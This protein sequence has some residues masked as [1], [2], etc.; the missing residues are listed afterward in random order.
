MTSRDPVQMQPSVAPTG[1]PRTLC[2]LP[3]VLGGAPPK[4][5]PRGLG[6]SA[7]CPER[8]S[9]RHRNGLRTRVCSGEK[10]LLPTSVRGRATFAKP[11]PGRPGGSAGQRA[12]PRARCSSVPQRGARKNQPVTRQ[13]VQQINVPCTLPSKVNKFKKT[14]LFYSVTAVPVPPASALPCS[15][16]T[17]NPSSQRRSHP[18]VRAKKEVTKGDQRHFFSTVSCVV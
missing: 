17:P 7:C 14:T 13:E 10:W 5:G 18:T 4:A 8:P 1:R 12:V 3:A 6:R 2:L 11:P 16:Q 15:V 9:P